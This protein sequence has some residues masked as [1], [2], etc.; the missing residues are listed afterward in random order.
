MTAIIVF[1]KRWLPHVVPLSAEINTYIQDV[2]QLANPTAGAYTLAESIFEAL[3]GGPLTPDA[4]NT[5][6][7][8][9]DRNSL[10]GNATVYETPATDFGFYQDDTVSTTVAL[11]IDA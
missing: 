8:F 1:N 4:S 9:A 6:P 3:G 2:V 5:D 7:T 10:G 11:D